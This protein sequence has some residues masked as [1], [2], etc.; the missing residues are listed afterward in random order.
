MS[1]ID[2]TQARAARGLPPRARLPLPKPQPIGLRFK[3][4]DA[5][6]DSKSRR[7]GR[8]VLDQGEYGLQVYFYPC[9]SADGFTDLPSLRLCRA[10]CWLERDESR[11]PE[12][13][14]AA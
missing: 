2:F 10:H 12:P 5:V 4:G 8:V 1:V 9:K 7:R 3:V 14:G 11:D 13:K 6:V